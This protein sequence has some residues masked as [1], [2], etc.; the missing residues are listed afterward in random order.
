MEMKINAARTP[1]LDPTPRNGISIE[2]V[3][4]LG[5]ARGRKGKLIVQRLKGA[6]VIAMLCCMYFGMGIGRRASGIA[7]CGLLW[8]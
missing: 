4:I 7:R 5:L 1:C 2:A 8:G 3:E 6:I